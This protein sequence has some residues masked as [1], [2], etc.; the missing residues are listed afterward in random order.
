MKGVNLVILLIFLIGLGLFYVGIKGR[1]T[2][3]LHALGLGAGAKD[4]KK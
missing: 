4:E 3:F 2:N 1:S